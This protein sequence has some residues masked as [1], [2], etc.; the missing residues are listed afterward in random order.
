[1]N[2]RRQTVCETDIWPVTLVAE[3][4]Y[5]IQMKNSSQ[6]ILQWWNVTDI[7]SVTTL[8]HLYFTRVVPVDATVYFY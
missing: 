8:R 6:W 2:Q 4:F 7:Y 3:D 1:M 5:R